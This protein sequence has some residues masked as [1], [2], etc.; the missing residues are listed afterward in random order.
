MSSVGRS[1]SQIPAGSQ[2]LFVPQNSN[3]GGFTPAQLSTSISDVAD[4]VLSYDGTILNTTDAAGLLDDISGN[5]YTYTQATGDY[6]NSILSGDVYR[7]LG[8]Q[9]HLLE[10][11]VKIAVFRLAQRVQDPSSSIHNEGV[12]TYPNLFI[13]T[14]QAAGVNC[15]NAYAMVKVVR[16]G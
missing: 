12:G 4:T 9:L 16:T 15:P 7:D 3:H 1:F 2:Y 6:Y 8:K 5:Y 13:C 10:K 14:W 11:G